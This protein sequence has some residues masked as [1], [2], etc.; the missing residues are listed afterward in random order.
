MPS[1]QD[2]ETLG[3]LL[4]WWRAQLQVTQQEL[5]IEA[6]CDASTIS[7]IERNTYQPSQSVLLGIVE[8]LDRLSTHRLGEGLPKEDRARFR[9]LRLAGHAIEIDFGLEGTKTA[10]PLLDRIGTAMLALVFSVAAVSSRRRL[11]ERVP[12]REPS[13]LREIS[14]GLAVGL[15]LAV[16][17]LVLQAV[18]AFVAARTGTRGRRQSGGGALFGPLLRQ[19]LEQSLLDLVVPIA[20]GVCGSLCWILIRPF[21][22]GAPVSTLDE[23]ALWSFTYTLG[24]VLPFFFMRLWRGLLLDETSHSCLERAA[25]PVAVAVVL[26]TLLALVAYALVFVMFPDPVQ[27]QIDMAVSLSVQTGWALGLAF[28]APVSLDRLR[29]D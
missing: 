11:L 4:K 18:S 8:A 20:G 7:R 10:I 5:G 25:C 16:G 13:F 3:D 29:R 17:V 12:A 23:T 14:W 19:R 22:D 26:N 15:G 2:V 24:F 21:V 9:E 6:N 28:M 27:G 1:R